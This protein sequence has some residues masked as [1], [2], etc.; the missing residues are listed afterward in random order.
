MGYLSLFITNL[1]SLSIFDDIGDFFSDI[2][3][4]FVNLPSTIG[5]AIVDALNSF[6]GKILYYA[7][8]KGM[9]SL[10]NAT[11]RIFGVFAGLTKVDYDGS[12]DYL[13]NVFFNNSIITNIYWMMACIGIA[14]MF[15]FAIV[16]VTKKTFDLYDKQRNSLGE[17]LKNCFK[18]IVATLLLSTILVAGVN[19][20]NILMQSITYL[21]D[22]AEAIGQTTHIEFTEAQFA[23]MARVINTIGN[24]S[25]NPS[26]ENR[27]NINSCFNDIRPDLYDLQRQGVF[28][29]YYDTEDESGGN[30]SNWLTLL[31]KIVLSTDLSKDLSLDVY[32]DKVSASVGDAMKTIQANPEIQSIK[33]YSWAI[34]TVSNDIT[35]DRA[36]FLMGT[37]GAARSE[38]Y[39]TNPSFFDALRGPFYNGDK[40]IYDIED[41][42]DA[43]N[44]GITGINYIIIALFAYLTIKYLI[45]AIVACSARIFNLIGLYIVAPPFIATMPLDDGEKFK[46]WTSAFIIQ[47]FGIFGTV[48]PMRLMMT[49]MPIVFSDKLIIFG[50]GFLN[51]IAKGLLVL[52]GLI[53][54]NRFGDVITG[55]LANNAS[56]QAIQAGNTNGVADK[57]FGAGKALAA[58]G[59]KMGLSVAGGV[60][61]A[62]A[63]ATGLT[64]LGNKIKGA[65]NSVSQGWNNF[66]NSGGVGGMIGRAMFGGNKG[67][68]DKNSPEPKNNNTNNSSNSNPS[69]HSSNSSSSSGNNNREVPPP[70]PQ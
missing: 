46:Q 27:Y 57:V 15:F 48:I 51:M 42:S 39:N 19:G 6:V 13:I 45:R 7:I 21:F 28:D 68:G 56:M 32:Y 70:R 20:T 11:Y 16:A 34:K 10:V 25:M 44:I 35:I 36:L 66:K 69:N 49:L 30:I 60:G 37:S 24:Y 47:C 58:K 52:G 62:V 53:S 31:Q 55:I 4:F 65:G 26:Y 41:V 38:K 23:S 22:N 40:N 59:A 63:G 61:G 9:L 64:A 5:N 1:Y 14:M 67:G 8:V 17:I 54:A 3:D 50:N 2:G 29:G 33:E 18:S 43:F 12:K